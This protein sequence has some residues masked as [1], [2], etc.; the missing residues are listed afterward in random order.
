[1]D[2]AASKGEDGSRWCLL[3]S[4]F[5]F[6]RLRTFGLVP[7]SIQLLAEVSGSMGAPDTH[8]GQPKVPGRA[9]CIPSENP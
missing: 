6:P 4:V 2:D 9:Q 1:V 7:D 3:K 5:W 8:Q